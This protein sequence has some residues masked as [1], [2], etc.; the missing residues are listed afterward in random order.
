MRMFFEVLVVSFEA[1]CYV[2]VKSVLIFDI[3]VNWTIIVSTTRICL[4]VSM[5]YI[6]LYLALY[7]I[8]WLYSSLFDLFYGLF[9][10]GCC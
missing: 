1:Y 6:A 3:T 7:S 5:M 4:T 8:Q 10:V 2:P 9:Y